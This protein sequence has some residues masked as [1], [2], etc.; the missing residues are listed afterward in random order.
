[1]WKILEKRADLTGF[2]K[3]HVHTVDLAGLGSIGLRI[4]YC[5]E[6]LVY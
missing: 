6:Q 1:M 2:G 3:Y 5:D 4:D